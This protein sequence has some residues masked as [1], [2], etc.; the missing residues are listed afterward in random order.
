M[1]LSSE[2]LGITTN[3]PY[4]PDIILFSASY[5][6]YVANLL[7]LW[8]NCQRTSNYRQNQIKLKMIKM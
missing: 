6:G 2:N 3:V 5:R 4:N 1:I 7:L 8:R